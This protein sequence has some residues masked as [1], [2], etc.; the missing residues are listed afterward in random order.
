MSKISKGTKVV[1]VDEKNELRPGVVRDVYECLGIAI[2]DF[3]EGVYKK[4]TLDTIAVAP[5]E[6]NEPS[7]APFEKSE[8]TIT[9]EAFRS[10]CAKITAEIFL[11]SDMK[12]H[13]EILEAFV[14]LHI[15]LF[16]NE[17]GGDDIAP[18]I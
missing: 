16:D 6:K 15:A 18:T 7:N 1:V 2:V 11:K 9:P 13:S 14:K 8:I 17:L 12:I 10:M 4:V 5:E 3:G